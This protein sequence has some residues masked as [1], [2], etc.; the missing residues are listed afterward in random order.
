MNGDGYDD[1]MIPM[2]TGNIIKDQG[3]VKLFLG[4]INF[5][6]NADVIFH[7]PGTDSLNDLAGG[8]GIGDVNADGYDDFILVGAFG[9]WV[10]PKGKYFCITVVKR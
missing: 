7:Y 10:F 9:D 3:I 6:L 8:Y 4:S 1:F 5:E 2:R